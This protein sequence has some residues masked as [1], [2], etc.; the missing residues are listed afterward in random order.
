MQ[1]LCD[2]VLQAGDL[3]SLTSCQI[4]FVVQPYGPSRPVLV[5]HTNDQVTTI[6]ILSDFQSLSTGIMYKRVMRGMKGVRIWR[7]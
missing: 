5:V 3:V 7:T 2:R 1:A 6:T 4:S